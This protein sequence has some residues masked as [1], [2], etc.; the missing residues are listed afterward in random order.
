MDNN[1][2]ISILISLLTVSSTLFVVILQRKTEKLKIIENQLSQNKYKAY[3][4][5][6][7]VFYST[8]KKI[9]MNEGDN[10]IELGTKIFNAKKDILMF[11]SDEVF[12]KYTNWLT[13]TSENPNDPKHMSLFLD[14]MLEIRKDMRGNK[15]GITKTDIMQNLM[16]D[17]N[18][19]KKLEHWWLWK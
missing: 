7:E 19:L 6:V 5:L 9:K 16:Q 15:T 12:K 10:S 14:L 2:I 1:T 3:I 4:D 13:Y 18:E 11:G 8:I 17:R